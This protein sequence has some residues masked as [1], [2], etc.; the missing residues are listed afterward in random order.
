MFIET[1]LIVMG[2]MGLLMRRNLIAIGFSFVM[3]FFG[4]LMWIYLLSATQIALILSIVF[5]L[6]I[7]LYGV[8]IVFV[9]RNKGT[10]HLDEIRELRG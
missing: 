7:L 4:I 1:A 2:F 8:L 5:S 10:L 3:I 9:W 6:Q